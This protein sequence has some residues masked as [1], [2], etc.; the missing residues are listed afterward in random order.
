M[1]VYVCVC[2]YVCCMYL[3]IFRT[4]KSMYVCM[5]VCTHVRMYLPMYVCLYVKGEVQMGKR[6]LNFGRDRNI[7]LECADG[8]LAYGAS[9]S[10]SP[11]PSYIDRRLVLT[12]DVNLVTKLRMHD[13]I[14]L[15]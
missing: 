15:T 7:L 6:A 14:K 11:Y 4:Y 12:N 5:L 8:L 3:R 13:S 10:E 9:S 1:C 2:M